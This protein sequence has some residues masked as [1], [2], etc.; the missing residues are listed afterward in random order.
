MND[1]ASSR[2]TGGLEGSLTL[3]RIAGEAVGEAELEGSERSEWSETSGHAM[4]M[5]S[6]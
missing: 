5:Q 1:M 4:N 3:V 2:K 6:P